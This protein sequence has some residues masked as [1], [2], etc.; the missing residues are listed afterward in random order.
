MMVA[1]Q[2]T[3]LEGSIPTVSGP[4][5]PTQ[6]WD[7]ITALLALH[8][9]GTFEGAAARLGIDP[10]TVRR[11][12]QALDRQLG[13]SV[14]VRRDGQLLVSEQQQS[15]L[16]HALR[17]EAAYGHLL[18]EASMSRLGGR[19]R[20]TTLDIFAALLAPD[21]ARLHRLHPDLQLEVTTEPHF[22]DLERDQIDVAIRL[23]RPLRGGDGLKR[24]ATMH[25]AI[26]GACDGLALDGDRPALLALYPHHDRLDHDFLLADERWY[27]EFGSGTIVARADGYPTLLRFCEERMGLALLPCLLGDA[28][29]RLQRSRPASPTTEIGVWAV[30]RQDVS[31]LPKVRTVLDF[32]T[33]SFRAHG[34]ALAGQGA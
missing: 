30:I 1:T 33:E 24:L 23:A 18:A 28:S 11:R 5:R 4:S 26:Y 31:K 32:L 10:T 15:T 17:M 8:R 2:R 6:S 25:F 12:I 3:K 27:E 16:D 22:V 19:L 14:F 9:A 34:P 29:P 21:L 20:I 7:L 13:M